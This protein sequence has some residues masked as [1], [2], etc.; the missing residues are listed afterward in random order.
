MTGSGA[1]ATPFKVVTIVDVGTTGLLIQQTDTYVTGREYY[2]TQIM[3]S[4]NGADTAS[5]V[6]YRAADAFLGGSDTG[7]GFTQVF[8]G[9]RKAVG[10]SV[11]A[12]NVPPGKIEEFI[13]LTGS[14]NFFQD[15]FDVVWN[16]IGSKMSLVDSSAST[17]L[18]DNGLAISWDFSIPAGGSATYSHVTTF[19]PLGLEGLVTS[20]TADSPT[21]P[22]GTQNGYTITI[23]N[24]NANCMLQ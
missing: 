11:N 22:V 4:N 23:Q 7:Y 24:P 21:S 14:N 18:L 12:N 15:E 17:T 10:C 5:G 6:L 13:P 1:A 16:A 19:S 20:K 8:S 3:I 2:T 9:N